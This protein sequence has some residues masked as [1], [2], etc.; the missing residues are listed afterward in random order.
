[1]LKPRNC[2]KFIP[3]LFKKEEG[4]TR[5]NKKNRKEQKPQRKKKP[6]QTKLK[7]NNKKK[8]IPKC[9]LPANQQTWEI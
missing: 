1:M 7:Q 6:N 5:R 4:K 8:A 9:S 3:L 2:M